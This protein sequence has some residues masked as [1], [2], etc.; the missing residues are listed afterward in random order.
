M[1]HPRTLTDWQALTGDQALSKAERQL[2][3][4]CREGAP[5]K[6]GD[7]MLPKRKS[8]ART[9][10]AD[11][12][13]WLILGGAEDCRVHEWGVR[14]AGAYVE[15]PLDLSFAEAKGPTGLTNCR[16]GAGITALAARLQLLFLTGSAVKGLNLQGASVTQNVFL[17]GNF[18]AKGEVSLAGAKI[19]GQLACDG[20]SFD[21]A[22]GNALI[23]ER[24][25][26]TGDVF[27]S[28]GFSAK[29]EV[30]L[31]GAK[32]GGQLS[33]DGGSFENADGDA[34]IAQDAEI[35]SLHWKK[36]T[37]PSGSV[38]FYSAHIHAMADDA[39][40]WPER[41]RLFLDGM[42]YDRLVAT[43]TD[44]EGRLEW[45]AKGDRSNGAFT[46]QPYTQLAKVLREMG[47]ERDA[48]AVLIAKERKL[49][50]ERIAQDRQRAQE[51]WAGRQGVRGDIGWHWL[52]RTGFKLWNGLARRLVGYGYAPQFAFYWMVGTVAVLTGLY[53][54]CWRF[55]GMVPNSE[56]I[57]NSADWAAAMAE[58]PL[59][60]GRI[61]AE[62]DV[63]RHYE[64]FSALIYASDVFIP[65]IDFAQQSA[66][67]ATTAN[68]IGY[69]A[70]RLNFLA[71]GFGWFLTA[72]GAA[73]I[74]G[75]IRRD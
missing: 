29:G 63:G 59:A 25:E 9:I 47:H 24:A 7:G 56:V 72:M 3:E 41:G 73:A 62:S 27:L 43:F 75:I 10:R 57:L 38:D 18:K 55:G 2:I 52:R 4:C 45:L 15:G 16:F 39:K 65:L 51:L 6:L 49:A 36:V 17:R 1:A 23:A 19:G 5:C 64:T 37:V 8:K 13:R 34:L 71:E 20:G 61:W 40:S 26:V 22:G 44:A 67:T 14:L 11:L 54:L 33:C 42:R 28:D 66:G 58:S 74:T 12:L 53:L 21:N 60:P 31:V 70:F 48:R 69:V 32:I 30:S 35:G 46:P 50:A 68:W